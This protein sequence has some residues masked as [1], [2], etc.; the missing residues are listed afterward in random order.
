MPAGL[1]GVSLVPTLLGRGEQARHDELYFEYAGQ[2]ALIA[3]GWKAVRKGLK[4]GPGTLEL[5]HLA[6]DPTESRDLADVEPER[7]RAM[8]ARMHAARTPSATFPL[9]GADGPAGGSAEDDGR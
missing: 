7:A 8:L 1:D 3:D 5:Y 2:Q 9:P 6:E 4:R